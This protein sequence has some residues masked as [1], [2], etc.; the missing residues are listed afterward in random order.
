M[1]K[2]ALEMETKFERGKTEGRNKGVIL[3]ICTVKI[4][5][6]EKTMG[7]SVNRSI[8]FLG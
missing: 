3:P 6:E 2:T 4:T 1:H 5:F 7:A 8:E